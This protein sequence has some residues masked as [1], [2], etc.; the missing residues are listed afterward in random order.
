[1]F[2]QWSDYPEVITLVIRSIISLVNNGR[3]K[4]PKGRRNSSSRYYFRPVRCLRRRSDL[5]VE[6]VYEIAAELKLASDA[7]L[8]ISDQ[9]QRC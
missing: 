1:M 3:G 9:L 8:H 7:K 6:I 2:L 4:R 5:L